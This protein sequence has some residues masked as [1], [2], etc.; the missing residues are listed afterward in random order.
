MVRKR[1]YKRKPY[2]P[3]DYDTIRETRLLARMSKQD[4][5]QLLNVSLRSVHY[6]EGGHP[7][8]DALGCLPSAAYPDWL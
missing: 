8:A 3:V 7:C 5:A 6:W 2:K 4:V 1:R